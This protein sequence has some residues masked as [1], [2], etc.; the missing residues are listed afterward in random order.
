MPKISIIIPVYNKACY[1]RELLDE[2]VAQ[3]FSHYECILIDDGSSD[4][5]SEICD[6]VVAMDSRFD[7]RHIPNG[8]VSHARNLGL[9]LA[10]G[11]YITFIDSDDKIHSE[12]LNNLYTCITQSGADLVISG[13]QKFW[14]DNRTPVDFHLPYSKGLHT[15]SELL[16]DFCRVQK[17]TGIYGC[18][19]AKIFGREMVGD[20]RF[21]EALKLAEDFDFYL[22]LYAKVGTVYIDFAPYYFYRQAAEN[23]SALRSDYDCDYISQLHIYLR[24]RAFLQSVEAYTDENKRILDKLLQ[25]YVYFSAFYCKEDQMKTMFPALSKKMREEQIDAAHEN[26]KIQFVLSLLRERRYTALH[27]YLMCYRGLRKLIRRSV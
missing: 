14:E 2:I 13:Y 21:D 27:T 25:N 18:C 1:L 26:R 6:R 23:S 17:E 16:P 9:M 5:S 12:Y 7:V 4:G 15:M 11:E 10:H 19:T 24:F 20:I 3:S 22:K 8:G